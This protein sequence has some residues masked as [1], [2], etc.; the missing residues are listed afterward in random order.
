M[1]SQGKSANATGKRVLLIS[2]NS[3]PRGGGERYLVY[4]T[5]GLRELGVEVHALLSDATYMDLWQDDLATAGAIVHRERLIGLRDRRMRFLQSMFD[6]SQQ[7]RIAN[8]CQSIAPDAILVNQQ[9]DEDGLDYIAG[10][11]QAKVAPVGSTMHM[12][13]TADKDARPLGKLRGYLLQRWYATH[14]FQIIAVSTGAKHELESYYRLPTPAKMVHYGCD[15]PE[16]PHEAVVLPNDWKST[17][18]TI[19]FCGQF[20]TQ[21]HLDLL[22]ES[23]IDLR[24]R[25][26]ECNLLLVGDGPDRLM[27]QDKLARCPFSDWF[28][29]GWTQKPEKYLAQIDL[30]CMTSYFEGFPLALIEAG[31]RG[32]PFVATNFN[33][34]AD[35]VELAPWGRVVDSSNSIVVADTLVQALEQI[36]ARKWLAKDG[37]AEYR[38]Y[39]SVARMA[40]QTLEAIDCAVL[41]ALHAHQCT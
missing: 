41:P 5:Q 14:R 3:S 34:A 6:R 18:P 11:L 37:Q 2:S 33:G 21:K 17:F 30:Y 12:P 39:F 40:A 31:G 4:L 23:W 22:V 9:Y 1:L 13:M 8:F 38:A 35:L 24:R 15:F 29:T 25:G 27:L 26:I 36:D 19:G 10:A 7:N 32:L 20:V 16:I 28:V